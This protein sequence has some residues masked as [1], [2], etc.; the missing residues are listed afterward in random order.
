[1][2]DW[3]AV[4][5]GAGFAGLAAA[6]ELSWRGRSVLVIEARDRIGG[7]TRTD[8]V[9]GA[10]LEMGGTYVHWYQSH[11]WAE[12]DRYGLG[13]RPGA[14]AASRAYWMA[15]GALRQ[16]SVDDLSAFAGD[17]IRE[18]MRSSMDYLPVPYD[19]LAGDR[20][21]EVD[22]LSVTE[23]LDRIGIV[24]GERDLVEGLISTDFSGYPSEGAMSQ[25]FRWWAF[26]NG[27]WD[28]HFDVAG[29]Y[30]IVEGTRELARRMRDDIDA[31]IRFDTEVASVE[32][33]A[34]G[35]TVTTAAGERIRAAHAIVTV[36]LSVLDR[37]GF[38][39]ELNV[40]K[41]TMI[42][43]GQMAQGTKIWVK[44][45]GAI[46]PFLAIAP[47]SEVFTMCQVEYS[48]P[49]ETILACFGPDASL[50]S[51]DDLDAVQAAIRL[52]LPE[53]EVLDAH[54]H[55]WNADAYARETWPMLRPG[56]LTRRF[57]G[58]RADE[59]RI[60]FA[61]SIYS[62]AWGSFIDGAL[63][64]GIAKAREIDSALKGS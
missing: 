8:D 47:P 11:I 19:A 54:A 45:K 1:M 36:P 49:G 26:S 27:D 33:D 21:A 38:S 6:R 2:V 12:I 35:V 29:G 4:I 50:I 61:G 58:L 22:G 43:E 40:D 24:G 34:D 32:Q 48:L 63:E 62:A 30:K 53:I 14:A 60:R 64:T 9:W 20:I 31:E 16:G 15:D 59:G 17:R 7:R 56:Q 3:D 44:A 55:D 46:E 13:V 5:V 10:K 41:R 18:V 51:P 25:A 52:W 37:I 28:T 57:N 23:Y 39:P 42:S